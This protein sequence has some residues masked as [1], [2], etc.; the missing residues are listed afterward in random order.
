M[1]YPRAIRAYWG[2]GQ[3]RNGPG[4]IGPLLEPDRNVSPSFGKLGDGLRRLRRLKFWN[5]A[6]SIRLKA[7][8]HSEVT[9][10]QRIAP[11]GRRQS[12]ATLTIRRVGPASEHALHSQ[13]ATL[14]GEVGEFYEAMLNQGKTGE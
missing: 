10:V 13:L 14:S 7:V 12:R 5:M 1:R 2:Q 8:A 6:R 3:T 11:H 9:E 4:K